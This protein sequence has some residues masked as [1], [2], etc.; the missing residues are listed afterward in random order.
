M[1]AKILVV[2]DERIVALDLAHGLEHLGYEV[3]G[4]V[5]SAADAVRAAREHRPDVVLM[6]IHLDGPVDGTVAG[7]EILEQLRI[8]V[9][10]LTAYA[11]P[12]TLA[13]AE[14]SRPYG[15]LLKPFELRELDAC[16][17][18][19]MARRQAELAIERSQE[20]L[21]LA[22]EAAQLGVWEW[23]AGTG[24]VQGEGEFERLVGGPPML[25]QEH[26]QTLLSRV[27]PE[28]GDLLRQAIAKGVIDTT[29][30]MSGD[31]DQVRWIEC[32]ARAW[33][34]PDGQTDRVVGV[35][36]DVTERYR[37]EQQQRQA[38]AVFQTM[39]EGIAILDHDG[40]ITSVNPAFTTLTGHATE[41]VLGRHPDDFLHLRRHSADFYSLLDDAPVAYWQG[42]ID[43]RRADAITFPAWQHV[44]PVRDP[45]GQVTHYVLTFSDISLIRSAEAHAHYLA[46]HD[47]LTGLGNRHMLRSRLEEEIHRA[48]RTGRP[49]ALL[50]VDLDNFKLINDAHGHAA[51]DALISTVAQRVTA[52]LRSSDLAVRLGGDEFVIIVPDLPRIEDA[53]LIAEKL[54]E[55]IHEPLI[56]KGETIQVGAS[57]GIAIHPDDG[58]NAEALM[59]SADS[60]MYVAKARGRHRY[61]Y[62][63][64]DMAETTR[65][66][67]Q[68]EQGL[69]RALEQ[70]P[71]RH[72]LQLEFLPVVDLA[73]GQITGAEALVRWDHPQWGR[74]GPT[75]FI[76]I[77]E[78][79][80]LIVP[81]GLW[82]LR[83]ACRQ[84]ASWLAA[85]AAPLRL[86]VNVSVRQMQND[87]FVEDVAQVLRET[88]FP[89]QQLELEITESTLQSIAD[90]RS[91]LGR[92]RHLGV[93][94][95]L[96]DFGTGFSSLSLLKH[97]AI[98]RIKIDRSFVIDL[99]GAPL[100]EQVTH[101]I[102]HLASALRL[103][104]TA[105][106]VET[107]A[108]RS[109]LMDMGCLEGQGYLF[110]Q[111]LS[112]GNF[113]A[114]RAS[115][116]SM[117]LH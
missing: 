25:L 34:G 115:A 68:V 43:I 47:A 2:E 12:E 78:D 9:V 81:L 60:A 21:Q 49:L 28:D 14:A 73:A 55:G 105:E 22:L 5:A 48:S 114:L 38:H 24:L 96:D 76:Q 84:G 17:R 19:A 15:Y 74:V 69:R 23:Q 53:A 37:H 101:A 104:M 87:H 61:A 67:L 103:Q 80:G 3:V 6:D 93:K 70:Q 92:F 4:M 97:L 89:P 83:E 57:I 64:V 10:Y 113:Q 32:H 8:P 1:S 31:D 59:Q 54:L 116:A 106:G 13:R 50:F 82:V 108:Q 95:A 18:M 44:C 86:A 88:G 107:E 66:R 46:F 102:V 36:R 85:G 7:R 94:M 29:F 111:P 72:E 65:E 58:E 79:S 90:S 56:L 99:P 20:R 26:W 45:A 109:S 16:L 112:G 33:N 39:A 40:L 52:H 41:A 11:E 30:R 110:S 98:D 51:G 63:S 71:Q 62:F 100:D 91:M 75:R 117:S 27:Y 77:A 42:E 35:L